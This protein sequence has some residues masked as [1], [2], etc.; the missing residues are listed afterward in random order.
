MR[1]QIEFDEFVGIMAQ[2]MLRTDGAEEME[3]AFNLFDTGTDKIHKGD[4]ERVLTQMG[5]APLTKDDVAQLCSLLHVDAEGYVSMR[6]FK[7]LPCWDVPDGGGSKG[8]AKERTGEK[9]K[10]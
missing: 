1:A 3:H 4:I 6:E 5:S 10:S 7:K 9:P 2:R 8:K